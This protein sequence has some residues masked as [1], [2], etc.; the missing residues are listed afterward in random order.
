[1]ARNEMAMQTAVR[2]F[3]K[4]HVGCRHAIQNFNFMNIE[5]DVA[6]YCST[7]NT[8]HIVECKVG[9]NPADIGHAFGQL[10]AYKCVLSASGYDFL[11][12][13]GDKVG[14]KVDDVATAIQEKRLRVKFYVGLTDRAC[15]NIDLLKSMK[16]S[17]G[18]VGIIRVKNGTCKDYIREGNSKN[19]SICQSQVTTVSVSR[20]Y[21]HEGFLRAA[22]RKVQNLLS[23]SRFGIFKTEVAADVPYGDW[24]KFWYGKKRFHFEI[25]LRK[26]YIE[27]G[28]HLETKNRANQSLYNYLRRNRKAIRK[29]LG[30]GIQI[31]RWG[32]DWK[33]VCKRFPK[34]KLNEEQVEEIATETG[35]MIRTIKP[36]MDRWEAV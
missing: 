33:R 22:Q 14:V 13:F 1:M 34:I 8:F 23:G 21:T 16:E 36:L 6:G 32:S 19:Y 10:L 2:K 26:A 5:F 31:V 29:K 30:P 3:M 24:V 4:R 25:L 28:L 20:T 9:S 18:S 35:R 7:D 17:L 15:K 27:V 11:S 12:E